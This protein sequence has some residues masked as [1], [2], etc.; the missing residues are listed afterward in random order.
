M[1]FQLVCEIF[2]RNFHIYSIEFILDAAIK[3][4]LLLAL[5]GIIILTS[6]KLQS[7]LKTTC[8]FKQ[9]EPVVSK[10]REHL[11]DTFLNGMILMDY[12]DMG[13]TNSSDTGS[14]CEGLFA[15]SRGYSVALSKPYDEDYELT[16][17][18]V[19]LGLLNIWIFAKM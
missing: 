4:S 18:K 7:R 8:C 15:I 16:T 1:Q 14:S 6:C 13:E 3:A 9:S 5:I 2:K 12:E 19:S 10:E 17:D 11:F